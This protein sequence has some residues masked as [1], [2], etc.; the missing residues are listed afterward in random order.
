MGLNFGLFFKTDANLSSDFVVLEIFIW[1]ETRA[2]G[3]RWVW[4]KK[5]LPLSPSMANRFLKAKDLLSNL[6]PKTIP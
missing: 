5:I 4:Q 1:V 6:Y 2:A 3:F